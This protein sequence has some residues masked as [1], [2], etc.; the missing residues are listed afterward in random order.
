[1]LH[2]LEQH[3]S[4]FVSIILSNQGII[5]SLCRAYYVAI[6]DQKDA[7][8]DITLQLWKSFETFRGDS[9][10]GTWIYRVALNTILTRIRNDNRKVKIESIDS[11]ELTFLHA[12]ADDDVELLN[13]V[14]QSLTGL[15]KAIVILFL[16][17]Y[18]NKE[19]S[20][21]L[22]ITATNVSTRLNRVKAELKMK[23]KKH[24]YEFK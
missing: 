22:A 23:F 21:M 14:L 6:E 18:K 2:C 3:K 1:M 16:E 20:D 4:Q 7:F 8:Q 24:H 17:G 13:I 15:D 12:Q 19:I 9:Q 5:K 10:I 11:K